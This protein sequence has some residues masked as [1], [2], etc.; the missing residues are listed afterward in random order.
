[1]IIDL[2]TRSWTC[3]D[4]LGPVPAARLRREDGRRPVR[5]DTSP[6]ALTA[7]MEC[8]HGVFV[9][10]FRSERLGAAIPAEFVAEQ[11]RRHPGR[12]AGV[13]GIDPMA[14]D[15]REQIERARELGLVA[16]TVSPSA[17][18]FHPAHSAAMRTYE[19]AER[20]RMPVLVSRPV[21]LAPD[22]RMEFDQPMAWDEV[23]RSFPSLRLVIGGL[24]HPWID[25]T[26][27]LLAKHP[28]V[29]AD[30]AGVVSRPW[31]LF[32]ALQ[33]AQS[34]GVLEKLLFASGFP[35]ETPA[36]AIENLYSVNSFAHGTPLPSI[37]RSSL[38]TIVERDPLPLL[39]VEFQW[40]GSPRSRVGASS[41]AA[42]A[43]VRP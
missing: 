35:F 23:A 25:E 37:P 31:Q 18:G 2:Q 1:M 33:T 24:G 3:H 19:L 43:P 32:N 11:V 26:L 6:P 36:R 13:A 39:G 38:R 17:A 21:P 22:C 5:L 9:L 10:G 7:A 16:L 28:G 34:L 8:L 27:V 20:F 12:V 42:V 15:P 41:D 14:G 30:L 29:H 40:H 4:Q